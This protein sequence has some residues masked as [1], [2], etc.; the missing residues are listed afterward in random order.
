MKD[1][2]GDIGGRKLGRPKGAVAKIRLVHHTVA[3]LY[4]YDVK[5]PEIALIVRR[6]TAT[7]RNWIDLP[8]FQELIQAYRKEYTEKYQSNLDYRADTIARLTTMAGE[9]LVERLESAIETGEL[10]PIRDLMK[11]LDS[12]NDR[13]G[14]GKQETKVN[15]NVGIGSRLDNAVKV[16]K[17]V[18]EARATGTDNIV[19]F[20]RRV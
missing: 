3:Q 13:T 1:D 9:L 4:A 15:I 12:G 10:I 6:T 18:E 16:V 20:V 11:I 19:K 2:L 17:K 8:A 7:I 14:L 5:I